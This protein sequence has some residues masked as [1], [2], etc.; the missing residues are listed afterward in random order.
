MAARVPRLARMT[1]ADAENP[2]ELVRLLNA[3]AT[4][5]TSAIGGA[6]SLDNM[7]VIV[8]D[9]DITTPPRWVDVLVPETPWVNYYTG[10]LTPIQGWK[11]A[12]GTVHLRGAV[13][14]GLAGDVVGYLP[15][16]YWP[17][18]DVADV[19][20]RA[21]LQ[22]SA[23]CGHS[24]YVEISGIDGSIIPPD[25]ACMQT[26]AFTFLSLD[27]VSFEAALPTLEQ[28]GRPYPILMDVA[29]LGSQ[30][31]GV[32][33]LLCRDWTASADVGAPYPAITWDAPVVNGRQ[34]V[35]LLDL[36]GLLPERRYKV[37]L[38]VF[39]S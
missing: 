37:R 23:A 35:R 27:G 34:Y 19:T 16:A 15:E 26:G 11:D 38:A 2:R 33:V 31:R 18:R 21:T 10:D 17:T 28:P 13:S 4:N 6:L 20:T 8:R 39:G 7:N 30:P 14:G 29:G 24:G 32:V 9:L 36:V 3:F 1:E 5:V 12:S 25:S 22:S